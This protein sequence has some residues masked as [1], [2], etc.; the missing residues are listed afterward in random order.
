MGLCAA[1][2]F[3]P[4]IPYSWQVLD[5]EKEKQD[6]GRETKNLLSTFGIV[7]G[8]ACTAIGQT[9]GYSAIDFPGASQTLA[10]GI[11]KSGDIV[12]QYTMGGVT[13]GFKL[14][15]GQ[16]STIDYP[17]ATSTDVR[18]INNSGA[19]V[20]EYQTADTVFHAF[21]LSG[22]QFSTIDP[23]DSTAG[24]AWGINSTA[25]V[26]GQ[27]TSGG[28]THGFKLS[29]GQYV[30]IDPPGAT[31]T[32][33]TGINDSG[34]VSGIYML[35]GAVHAFMLSDG[36][37]TTIDVPGS[38]YTNSTAL[39]A[40]GEVIGR[41]IAGGMGY[42]YLLREGIFTRIGFPGATFTGAA[43][44]NDRGD[45][46]GRYQNA[47][48]AFHGF[49][50]TFAPH[51]AITTSGLAVT[52]SGDFRLVTVASPAAPGEVLSV[53]ATGLGA[54]EPG[55]DP[56]KPFPTNPLAVVTSVIEVRVNGKP[57]EVLGSV[58]LSGTVGG[59]QVNFRLPADTPKGSVALQL[60]A[61]MAADTSVKIMVQ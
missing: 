58:G 15:V 2:T 26:V 22:T 20:G 6:M 11:N 4:A 48:G 7:L 50:L 18:G 41:Y 28:V 14:S 38:T 33:A 61:G 29:K 35:S 54:T 59:Y 12:G 27:Y 17:G 23:P 21:L 31:T 16:F 9:G 8:V 30:S 52:H 1:V 32:T 39:T 44:M 57:A 55:V 25:D 51:V 46:V 19:V 3:S 10:W 53:F 42:G 45:M 47:D 43:A 36:A 40:R 49:L 56:G 24:L 60:S 13:H 37:F 5:S 34:E